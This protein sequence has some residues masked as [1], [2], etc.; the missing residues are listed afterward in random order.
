[1]GT[2]V[3]HVRLALERIPRTPRQWA[4]NAPPAAWRQRQRAQQILTPEFFHREY[5]T[6]GKPLRQIAAETRI[7]RAIVTGRA[8]HAGITPTTRRPIPID[9]D[10]LRQ[11]YLDRKRSAASIAAE[12]GISAETVLRATRGYGIP[13][14]T[15]GVA[16]HRDMLR[17]YD[18]RLPADIRRAVE[19]QRYGWQRLQRFQAA[20][21]HPNLATAARHLHLPGSA[22]LV[23]QLHRLEH[24][25]G[26]QLYHRAAPTQPMRPT[27]R[28]TALLQALAR[29]DI[30]ALIEEG[31]CVRRNRNTTR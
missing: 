25:I 8:K 11:Q 29:L 7:N 4:A 27:P 17:T 22:V 26:T 5:V 12:L 16:S 1:M 14:R 24:A 31:V 18:D 6:S 30:C 28:G 19:D 21:T 10:W 2:S 9:E 3:D 23:K 20:M 13:T 15:P